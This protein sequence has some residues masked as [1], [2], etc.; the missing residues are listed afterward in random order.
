MTIDG[1]RKTKRYR[2]IEVEY[3]DEDWNTH[4]QMFSGWTAQIIQHEMN[5]LN[6]FGGSYL[7]SVKSILRR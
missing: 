1:V 5:H 7:L 4:K 2:N 3:L 6:L